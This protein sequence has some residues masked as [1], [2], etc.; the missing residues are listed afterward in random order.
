MSA[1]PAASSPGPA[2]PGTAPHLPVDLT[3]FV[4][5][6][7]ELGE[8]RRLIGSSRL[9]TLTGAGGTG[10]SR[11]ARETVGPAAA[12]LGLGLA[13]AEL[14]SLDDATAVARHVADA[15]GLN[16]EARGG[17]V[18]ALAGLL[19]SQRLLL[20][21]DNC[22]HLVE[23]CATLADTLLRVCPGL[24][25]VAT[26]REALG[27]A[28]E[29]AWLVPP[30]GLPSEGTR[31]AR[32]AG[33]S[34]AVFL[35]SERARHAVAS[36]ELTDQNAATVVEIC[37]RLDGIPL[38]IELA[39]AR[40]RVLSV[41][42]IQ[43]RL[44]D[45]FRLL[46]AGGRSALP[47][48]RTL[49]AA[50]DWSY[51]L[52]SDEA[53]T[54]LRRL[55]VFRGGFSLEAVEAVCAGGEVDDLD[56]LDRLA[57]LV[58][59]S[60]V[61]VHD[62]SGQ[63][64]YGLLETVRQYA[65]EKLIESG[66]AGALRDRHALWVAELVREAE[67]HLI[68]R[69]RPRWMKRLGLELDNLREALAWTRERAPEVHVELVGRIG[70]FWISTQHWSEALR[71]ISDALALPESSQPTLVR[72]RLL[73]AAG[74]LE[75]LRG[76]GAE[77]R[78]LLNDAAALAAAHGD[79]A[80]EAYALTY[81]GMTW[82][83]HGDPRGREPCERAAR[84]FESRGDLY[85]LRLALLLLGISAIAEGDL[86]R[87]ET[88][89]REGVVVARRFGLDRELAVSL[90]NLAMVYLIKRDIDR[91]EP[92]VREALAASLRDP[93]YLSM[94]TGLLYMGEV[95]GH[96]GRFLDAARALGTSDAIRE[97]IG[98]RPLEVDRR[99]VDALVPGFRAGA[100]AE[101]FERAF[102]DG[103]HTRPLVAIEQILSDARAARDDTSSGAT[104]P[105]PVPE[106]GGGRNAAVS[107]ASSEPSPAPNAES[108]DAPKAGSSRTETLR[109]RALGPFEA[110]VGGERI[111][112]DSWSYV[113]P[114]ELL[115]LLLLH[116][117]GRTRDQIARALWPGA[118]PQ[119]ATN[120]F[121]VTVHH[122]RRTLGRPE[123]VER[124]SDRYRLAAH[125]ERWFDAEAF[126]TALAGLRRGSIRDA[127]P[128]DA[129][130]AAEL[131]DALE[132]YRG[133]LLEDEPVEAW[134]EDHRDRLR[135]LYVDGALALGG[136]L[137]AK[138]RWADA[139][140]LYSA[141]LAR[142]NL[143]EELHR[144]LMTCWVR[145]GERPRALKH[146]DRMARLLRDEL[147]A[148][149]EPA[150]QELAEMLRAG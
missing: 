118:T 9:L 122:L 45:A 29:R 34:E 71:W 143:N 18:N 2:S 142:E 46:T 90:Q 22:E 105:E 58:D 37:R 31:D 116:P 137:E 27:V 113:K 15:C 140:E 3:T 88:M 80:L 35:F 81:V 92:A 39:A 150:T 66:E 103:R 139:A 83:G 48:H 98:A 41:E 145:E 77:A 128:L 23:A 72:A 49:R 10:K 117:R 133:D 64:R 79:E 148:E 93:A 96:R 50:M 63:A 115:V 1:T 111:G 53:R 94:G 124:E 85:G 61:A 30:L 33:A 32:T 109:V 87:A 16:E 5:R 135:T 129:P 42:Q 82:A 91:A 7:R 4:G 104:R 146:Y 97:T 14:A 131:R 147:G 51:D 138:S 60:L 6:E 132:L 106:R 56:V 75:A 107:D 11:L 73:F 89:N 121:H 86:E 13:W 120:S 84:W 52:L 74:S 76:G 21:L 28:G 40:V 20:V 26:S 19:R 68:S 130:S 127:G 108:A 134:L 59:R 25:I 110:D 101:A 24:R 95:L 119:Q 44:D 144:R 100:G 123:W 69:E 17:D 65:A 57:R 67:P 112:A 38:A 70:W 43:D 136:H 102:A 78:A 125:V 141:A 47:R 8:L 149:P 55:S 12:E 99:R 54:L 62:R 36:W 114:R 126:E